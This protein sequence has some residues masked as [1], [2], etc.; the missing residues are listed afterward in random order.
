[1]EIGQ[2]ERCARLL[3]RALRL[4]RSASDVP[5]QP[6]LTARA[7][8]TL[9]HAQ[10]ELSGIESASAHLDAAAQLA[11][12]HD[13]GVLAV[14]LRNQRGVLL[15]R[16]GRY[17]DAVAAFDSSEPFWPAATEIDRCRVLLNRS[18]ARIEQN[19]LPAARSDLMTCATVAEAAGLDVLR[20]KAIHNL[21]YVEFMAGDL[22]RALR[23]MDEAYEI[24]PDVSPGVALLGK[25][26]VLVEAGLFSEADQTLAVAADILRRNRSSHDLAEAEL[27]RAKCALA[28]GHVSG[29]RRL[30]AAARKSFGRRGSA[31][32]RRGAEL[33]LLQAQLAGGTPPTRIVAAARDL[34]IEFDAD[35]LRLPTR[36]ATLIAAEAAVNARDVDGAEALLHAVGP[37]RSTDPIT[38]RTHSQLVQA[39]VDASAGRPELAGRRVRRALDELARYQASFGSIDLRTASAVHGRRLAE[40]DVSLA[41]HSGRPAAI[42]AAAERA[43]AVSSRLPAVRPPDDPVAAELLAEL[44]QTLDSLRGVEQDRAASAPLLRRRRELERQIMA[45]SWTRAGSG[46]V[47]RPATFA[48]V[49]QGLADRDAT[50]V[51]YVQAGDRLAAV[52]LGHRV[53]LCELGEAAPVVEQVRRARADLDVLANPRLPAAIRGA[54][55]A[56][57]QRTL[58]ELQAA[59]VER[60]D[61]DG[62]L[63]VVSTGVLGQVPWASLPRLAACPITVAPSATKWLVAA[64]TQAPRPGPVIALA[65]P[66][67]GRGAE[68]AAAVGRIWPAARVDTGGAATTSGLLEA[69]GVAAVLHVAAHGVHQP[70]NPLFSSV[71]M[72]DGPV[73]AH[74]LDRSHRAPDHVVL[75]ACEVGLATIRPGDEALGLAS[76]LL[77][78]GT[79]SVIAGVARVGDEVAEQTMAGYHARLAKG[80]DSSAALAEALA[81]VDTDVVPPFVNFGAAWAADLEPAAAFA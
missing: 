37:P 4:L 47:D 77:Q 19:E 2:A 56:S 6:E 39:R 5:G 20:I 49:R 36:A 54:V 24:D 81:D 66:D 73:F 42:F 1:M 35:G 9:A 79:R 78:L 50:M 69:M 18:V 15:L 11:V 14:P 30:A 12:E 57:L 21:G 62:P 45:R 59:L 3:E 7:L 55:R 34:A 67:L 32:F 43:R 26:Q 23:L 64:A 58:G 17:A 25:A 63:V 75:S 29:A 72:A 27:E 40:L 16:A 13:L 74:E 33:V 60:L 22:P 31:Q 41:W 51:T 61:V 80:A 71:R 70:E 44:R 8:I 65:G 48:A 68:E 52:V 53:R 76:V 10:F 46:A 38:G 28:I